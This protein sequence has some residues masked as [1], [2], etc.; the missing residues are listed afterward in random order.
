[1]AEKVI[2]EFRVKENAAGCGVEFRHGDRSFT[3]SG[4]SFPAWCQ[5]GGP[6]GV[7]HPGQTMWS[8]RKADETRH[9]MRETLDFLEQLYSDLFGEQDSDATGDQ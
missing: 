2:F 7:H 9:H 4:T 5:E 1:M 3:V 8:H 6:V